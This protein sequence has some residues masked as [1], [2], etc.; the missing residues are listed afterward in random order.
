[1]CKFFMVFAICNKTL[2]KSILVIFVP[3]RNQRPTYRNCQAKKKVN[4]EACYWLLGTKRSHFGTDQPIRIIQHQFLSS[5]VL[6]W[7]VFFSDITNNYL[8]SNCWILSFH[9]FLILYSYGHNLCWT[10]KKKFIFLFNNAWTNY[11]K[12]RDVY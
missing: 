9:S 7:N 3:V 2:F 4:I 6:T 8:Q 10:T 12:S 5:T 1:M 11:W